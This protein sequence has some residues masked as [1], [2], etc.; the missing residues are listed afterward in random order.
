MK[1]ITLDDAIQIV[2]TTYS[3]DSIFS[4]TYTYSNNDSILFESDVAFN[5]YTD[6]TIDYMID[7][8]PKTIIVSN[9]EA[10]L[11]IKFYKTNEW[12]VYYTTDNS[13]DMY[14]V[15]KNKDLLKCLI[16]LEKKLNK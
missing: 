7:S 8:I 11:N 10:Y 4:Y 5:C 9:T 3:F 2:S 16:N 12:V 6:V 13:T 15:T 14:Y 1:Y